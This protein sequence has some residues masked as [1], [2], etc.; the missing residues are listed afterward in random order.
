MQFGICWAFPLHLRSVW[1]C[2]IVRFDYRLL[3]SIKVLKLPTK[4]VWDTVQV[5]RV[6]TLRAF[7]EV[8][9]KEMMVVCLCVCMYSIWVCMCLCNT[10]YCICG[11]ECRCALSQPSKNLCGGLDISVIYGTLRIFNFWWAAAWQSNKEKS[12][13]ITKVSRLGVSHS[14]PAASWPWILCLFSGSL[15]CLFHLIDLT[16]IHTANWGDYRW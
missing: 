12:H 16:Q 6:Q 5:D 1:A 15:E 14:L 9:V 4:C 10:L 7:V 2:L 8:C 3:D 13:I 11:C